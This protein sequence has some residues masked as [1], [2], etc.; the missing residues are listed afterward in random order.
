MSQLTSTTSM[1]LAPS[2]SKAAAYLELTKPR[3][4]A[5]VLV[6][7]SVG[8]YL[9]LSNGWDAAAAWRLL[10]T[11]IGTALVAGGSSALNQLIEIDR[12]ARMHR[13]QNRPLP[14]NRLTPSEV[15]I[16]GVVVT[17]VGAFVLAWQ[18]N[19]LTAAYALATWAIYVFIY[20]PMKRW[21]PVSVLVGA[22]AGALP[23]VIGWAGGAGSVAVGG[24]I[25]FLIMFFWQLPH[26]AAIA[27]MYRE[28]YARAGYPMLP[29]TD[30]R[31]ARIDLHV[32]THSVA[33]LIA[34]FLPSLWRLTGITYA[35]SAMVLGLAFLGFGVMFVL[36]KQRH[37]ARRLV[38]ASVIYLPILLA[39][40]M[41]DKS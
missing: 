14:T 18:V 39:L 15:M 21:G 37:M 41:F 29:V 28:D 9:S 32:I 31:G 19:S 36:N 27:W 23:P 20:T 5:L 22:V 16:F 34:T 3:I 17:V 10:A 2:T 8:F 4:A 30:E 13:T 7:T 40:M 11:V 12:D 24:W 38:L 35:I 1:S 25:L 33:L 6:T 26:F